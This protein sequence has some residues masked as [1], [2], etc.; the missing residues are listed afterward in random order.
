MTKK[1]KKE[2]DNRTYKAKRKDYI[3]DL[4]GRCTIC[5]YHGG[6]NAKRKKHGTKK[7]KYKDK[8]K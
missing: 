5:P 4:T 2:T 6:E 8:R 3:C 7:P 1:Y